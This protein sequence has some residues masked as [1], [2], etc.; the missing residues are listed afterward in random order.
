MKITSTSSNISVL[1]YA[2]DL[3]IILTLTGDVA[4]VGTALHLYH[5]AAGASL[6]LTKPKTL[7][8]GTLNPET[9]PMGISYVKSENVLYV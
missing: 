2:E 7:T 4:T 1:S 5:R 8:V 9:D 6:S 3:T